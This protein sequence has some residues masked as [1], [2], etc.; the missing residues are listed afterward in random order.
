MCRQLI[1]ILNHLFISYFV[2]KPLTQIV[3]LIK[4]AAT[5]F[6]R[7]FQPGRRDEHGVRL[8]PQ[9]LQAPA[10]EGQGAGGAG[11]GSQVRPEND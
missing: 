1:L 6:N 3:F 4:A 5:S 2:S 8:F 7:S 9:G 10:G 11:G